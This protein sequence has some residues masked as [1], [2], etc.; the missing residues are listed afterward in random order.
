MLNKIKNNQGL[1]KNKECLN[2]NAVN[3]IEQDADTENNDNVELCKNHV[4]RK[5]K[6]STK[7]RVKT[8]AIR[9]V[10]AILFCF[11]ALLLL[12]CGSNLYQNLFNK[13]DHTGF[14]GVGE[15]IVVSNSMDTP[16]SDPR[17]RVNDLVFYKAADIDDVSVGD[18]VIY[19]KENEGYEYV[20]QY[21]NREELL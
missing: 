8:I 14:F 12:L 13:D 21:Y 15:A 18:I 11:S 5:I 3:V 4:K 6:F 9:V 2:E 7:K 20:K 10:S 16:E 17:I 19:K 1:L